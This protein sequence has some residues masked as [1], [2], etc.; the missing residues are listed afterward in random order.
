MR[1][2]D[3]VSELF[4]Q[5]AGGTAIPVASSFNRF[6]FLP[7]KIVRARRSDPAKRRAASAKITQHSISYIVTFIAEILHA[8]SLDVLDVL[9]TLAISRATQKGNGISRNQ[10]SRALNVPLETVRRRVAILLAT[11]II[12][13]REGGLVVPDR[14]PLGA[15]ANHGELIARNAQALGEL[16]GALKAHGI[17]LG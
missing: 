14:R 15:L 5:C 13:E 6:Q 7:R 11:G 8:T 16:F 17:Q 10:L 1:H 3:K 9:I 2:L 12:R 4:L